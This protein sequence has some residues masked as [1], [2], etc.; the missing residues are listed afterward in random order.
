[1]TAGE[2]TVLMYKN[3]FSTFSTIQLDSSRR[4]NYI[5]YSQSEYHMMARS[6]A[7]YNDM[8]TI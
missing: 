3:I 1:M 2:K 4:Y 6:E 7:K 5:H 8:I